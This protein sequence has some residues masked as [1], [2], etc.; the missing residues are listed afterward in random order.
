MANPAL[1]QTSLGDLGQT[2]LPQLNRGRIVEI[3]SDIQEY[4]VSKFLN[5]Q[6]VVTVDGGKSFQWDVMVADSGSAANVGLGYI[7]QPNIVDTVVQATADWRH[8]KV[9]WANIAQELQMNKGASQIVDLEMLR[10]KAAMIA[11]V[12]LMENNLWGPPVTSSDTIT[13]WGIKTWVVKNATQGFNGSTQSGGNSVLGL[14]PSTWTRWK[15][16]TDQYTDVTDTD[17]VRRMLRAIRFTNFRPPVDG[18]PLLNGGNYKYGLYTNNGLLAPAEEYLK[19]SN[20]SLGNDMAK[21]QGK[22]VIAGIPVQWVPLL[23]SDTTNP[24]YLLNHNDVK[25][26]RLKNWWMR[27]SAVPMMPG[28]H[29]VSG[30]FYDTTMQLVFVTRRGSGVLATGTTEPS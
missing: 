20:D 8:L 13:P 18:L 15:N 26:Y 16:Y 6:G 29:T 24:I 10:E 12:K 27:R 17:F 5:K 30:Y 21:Y 1:M 4:T 22:L 3:T 2:T 9:D 11:Q 23:E 19:A 7:D 28:Q 14:N 25:I